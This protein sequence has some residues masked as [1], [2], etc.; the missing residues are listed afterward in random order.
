M[1]TDGV[2]VFFTFF[3]YVF[4]EGVRMRAERGFFSPPTYSSLD[5]VRVSG[6]D[7][8]QKLIP[9]LA[10]IMHHQ[11]FHFVV[12]LICSAIVGSELIKF[13]SDS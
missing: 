11:H 8:T 3:V 13:W 10:R 6:A 1:I 5:S 4:P 9:V 2:I 7:S 12:V